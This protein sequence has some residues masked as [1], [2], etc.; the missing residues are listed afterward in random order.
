M[1]WILNNQKNTIWSYR[2]S[3]IMHQLLLPVFY[4]LPIS[5]WNKNPWCPRCSN[6]CKTSTDSAWLCRCPCQIHRRT[7]THPTVPEVL[8]PLTYSCGTQSTHF[9]TMISCRP[10]PNRIVQPAKLMETAP[11]QKVR[12][13]IVN[14]IH[15]LSLI[16]Y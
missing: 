15:K 14:F 16:S 10:Q 9:W 6:H 12:K 3:V 13:H 7:V 2:F 11:C 8:V 1:P 4:I 5:I